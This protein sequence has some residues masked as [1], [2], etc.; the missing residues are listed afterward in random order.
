MCVS[1]ILTRG[2][3]FSQW[4]TLQKIKETALI[5]I[6]LPVLPFELSK[7]EIPKCGSLSNT[8]L[9]LDFLFRSG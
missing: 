6:P 2:I 9:N 1:F 5:E 4:Y 7:S 3:K 8:T